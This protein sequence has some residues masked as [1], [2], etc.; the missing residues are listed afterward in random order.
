M[1]PHHGADS[2]LPGGVGG[3]LNGL[4]AAMPAHGVMGAAP[5]LAMGSAMPA[6]AAMLTTAIPPS[7]GTIRPTG[8]FIGAAPGVDPLTG[9]AAIPAG[10][11]L[12]GGRI[13]YSYG[14][15]A[16]TGV[17]PYGHP[18]NSA[19]LAHLGHGWSS[20][21]NTTL[22]DWDTLTAALRYFP[23][24]AGVGGYPIAAPNPHRANHV[25][26]GWQDDGTGAG[27]Q[28]YLWRDV[29]PGGPGGAGNAINRT[30]PTC[31]RNLQFSY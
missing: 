30:C 10:C 18:R 19:V 26:L 1:A 3:T 9:I 16:N 17:H 7:I 8:G 20:R 12:G 6:A 29:V 24:F 14:I 23:G 2:W 11:I 5:V 21:M 28:T 22:H 15:R 27:T 13:A 25:A 4:V 31:A